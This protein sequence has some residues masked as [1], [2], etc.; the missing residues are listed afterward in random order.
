MSDSTQTK[1]ATFDVNQ[2]STGGSVTPMASEIG[3]GIGSGIG[4]GIGMGAPTITGPTSGP[5]LAG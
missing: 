4:G 5:M 2:G 1:E 3:G